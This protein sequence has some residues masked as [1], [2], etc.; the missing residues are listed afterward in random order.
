MESLS[1]WRCISPASTEHARSCSRKEGPGSTRPSEHKRR[2]A[3]RCVSS[4]PVRPCLLPKLAQPPEG[5][6][7]SERI[8]W[9]ESFGQEGTSL[10][11][12][13]WH[14]WPRSDAE[15]TAFERYSEWLLTL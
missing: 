11:R 14:P 9:R 7:S 8:G 4:W 3:H 13:T 1:E 12:V 5:P 15:V 10:P 6:S 2:S